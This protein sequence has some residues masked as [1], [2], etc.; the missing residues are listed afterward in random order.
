[1]TMKDDLFACEDQESITANEFKKIVTTN[2]AETDQTK[3][4]IQM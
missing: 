4:Y 3:R 2:I 1:M